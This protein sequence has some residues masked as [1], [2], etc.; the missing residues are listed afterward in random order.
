M[1]RPITSG[2][3]VY[4]SAETHERLRMEC[5]RRALAGEPITLGQL[6]AEL[7]DAAARRRK[8]R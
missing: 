6:V 8:T 1:P 4:V 3:I 7:L 2:S 5:A